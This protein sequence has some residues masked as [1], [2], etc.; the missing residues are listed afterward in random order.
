MSYLYARRRHPVYAKKESRMVPNSK[1]QTMKPCPPNNSTLSGLYCCTYM[2][3]TVTDTIEPWPGLED[4]RHA[5]HRD[6][7]NI[8]KTLLGLTSG[9]CIHQPDMA[10]T[11][12]LS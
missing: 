7:G 11:P 5:A 6:L 2:S 12:S 4:C 3:L 9:E 10:L 8:E 1:N